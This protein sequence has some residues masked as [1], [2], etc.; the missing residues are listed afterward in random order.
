MNPLNNA[1]DKRI[2]EL[3]VKFSFQQETID[4]LNEIVTQQWQQID[5]LK[6][7]I[8]RLEG[9]MQEVADA[10]SDAPLPEPPPPHY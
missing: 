8:E 5:L 4:S 7:H 3:E 9:R 6:R 10:S 2:A 1:Q